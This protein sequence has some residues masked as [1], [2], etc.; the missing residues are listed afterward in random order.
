MSDAADVVERF[1]AALQAGDI[2]AVRDLYAPDCAVWHNNDPLVTQNRDENL[3]VLGW[4]TRNIRDLRYEDV[5][6]FDI[7]GGVFQ[8]HVLRGR[9]PGGDVLEVHAAMRIEVRDGRITRIEEY[10]DTAQLAGLRRSA[11]GAS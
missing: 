4:V 7:P 3:L 5:R 8:Q 6:R 1:F 11:Q 10:L 2:G 9:A